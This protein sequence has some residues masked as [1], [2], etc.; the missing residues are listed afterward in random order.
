[1]VSWLALH[2]HSPWLSGHWVLEKAKCSGHCEPP[3]GQREW[4]SE[5]A[6]HSNEG[7]VSGVEEDAEQSESLFEIFWA[8]LLSDP[9][10]M[11]GKRRGWVCP[12]VTVKWFRTSLVGVGWVVAARKHPSTQYSHCGPWVPFQK[13]W[14][15]LESLLLACP[16]QGHLPPPCFPGTLCCLEW[17]LCLLLITP[18]SL[19][20]RLF[21][22][23]LHPTLA[24]NCEIVL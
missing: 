11:L 15:A 20:R 8:Y 16:A 3:R 5:A 17:S 7:A 13:L 19:P 18:F 12:S 21:I 24:P 6:P 10:F 23:R 4:P 1:M 22:R 9:E 2:L 14:R